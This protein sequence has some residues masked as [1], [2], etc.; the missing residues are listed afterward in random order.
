M[1]CHLEQERTMPDDLSRRKFSLTL[2]SIL[3]VVPSAVRGWKS[4]SPLRIG[5]EVTRNAE[6][7]LRRSDSTPAMFRF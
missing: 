1:F 6:A 7:I 3:G 5:D 4:S 2:A